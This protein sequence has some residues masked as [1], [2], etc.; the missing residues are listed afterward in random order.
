VGGADYYRRA[1]EAMGPH[2]L[3]IVFSDDIDWSFALH[4]VPHPVVLSPA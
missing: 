1:V 4:H 2:R 3:F